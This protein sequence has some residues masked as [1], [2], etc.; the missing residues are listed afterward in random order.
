MG[1][2]RKMGVKDLFKSGVAKF[3]EYNKPENRKKRLKASIEFEKDSL[4]LEKLRSKSDEL[5]FER[6][7]RKKK[8]QGEFQNPFQLY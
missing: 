5:K 8:R 1:A 7:E 4:E 3:K 2:K 6:S